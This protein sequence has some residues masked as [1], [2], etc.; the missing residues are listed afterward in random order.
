MNDGGMALAG[1]NILPNRVVH[2]STVNIKL[3]S[4][5]HWIKN[6]KIDLRN[7]KPAVLIGEALIIGQQIPA[8]QARPSIS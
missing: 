5:V 6:D 7:L 3:V 4:G 8:V 1:R 2:A